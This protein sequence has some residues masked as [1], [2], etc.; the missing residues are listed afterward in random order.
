MCQLLVRLPL[1]NSLIKNNRPIP[2]R[3]HPMLQLQI[4]CPTEHPFLNVL[5]YAFKVIDAIS[6]ADPF[7]VLGNDGT[8]VEVS[9][10]VVAGGTDEFDASGVGTLIRSC[11]FKGRQERMVDVG[12]AVFE[13]PAEIVGEDLHIPGQDHEVGSEFTE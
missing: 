4:N 7:Y 3:Q 8:F 11:A 9:S 12:D 2:K 5:T 1:V 10:N 6:V 13:L